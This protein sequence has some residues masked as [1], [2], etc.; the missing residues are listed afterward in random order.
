MESNIDDGKQPLI[1]K[2]FKVLP[3]NTNVKPK[4]ANKENA[5]PDRPAQPAHKEEN[6]APPMPAEDPAPDMPAHSPFSSPGIHRLARNRPAPVELHFEM[7]G[8][9]RGAKS[10]S[11]R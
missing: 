8:T 4:A 1:S 11:C 7:I 3:P 2:Y 6:Q 10:P 5:R 9:S